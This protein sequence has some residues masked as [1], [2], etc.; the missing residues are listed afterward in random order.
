MS[1]SLYAR[2]ID[3]FLG[4]PFNIASYAML[5]EMLCFTTGYTARDLII[6]FGD[7]HLY[8]NHVDQ[9]NIQLERNPYELPVVRFDAEVK[10]TMLDTLLGITWNDVIVAGYKSHPK[11]EAPVAV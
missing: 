10:S 9:A 4:L 7:L 5:L 1:L 3:I 8:N 11:I 2:S 6:S